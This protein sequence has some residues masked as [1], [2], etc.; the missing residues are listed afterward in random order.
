MDLYAKL[1]YKSAISQYDTMETN[2]GSAGGMRK[3]LPQAGKV[4]SNNRWRQKNG[5]P[6]LL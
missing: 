4:S 6:W 5:K 1:I 2:K 3:E